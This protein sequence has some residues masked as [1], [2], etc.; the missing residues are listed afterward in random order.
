MVLPEKTGSFRQLLDQV[1]TLAG[2]DPRCSL[3]PV[4]GNTGMAAQPAYMMLETLRGLAAVDY[5]SHRFWKIYDPS[6][7]MGS[8]ATSDSTVRMH[9]PLPLPPPHL[10][11]L[12]PLG[13]EPAAAV[14]VGEV[15]MLGM[16]SFGSWCLRYLSC[17]APRRA[18]P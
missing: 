14:V 18:M 10:R 12:A 17:Q 13:A 4:A 7:R 9:V 11:P 16:R 6:D 15:L 2:L 8:I 5:W 3:D 1:A